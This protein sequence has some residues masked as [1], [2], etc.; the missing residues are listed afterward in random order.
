MNKWLESHSYLAEWLAALPVLVS[1]L[2]AVVRGVKASIPI[3]ALWV[4]LG[5]SIVLLRWYGGQEAIKEIGKYVTL[6]IVAALILQVL[7]QQT[8][9]LAA[10]NSAT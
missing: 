2:R 5:S 7:E 8:T 1:M 3:C 4:F 6:V 10:A 9:Q